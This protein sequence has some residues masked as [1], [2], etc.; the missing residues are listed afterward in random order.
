MS[1]IWGVSMKHPV[2]AVVLLCVSTTFA[3][4]QT[5]TRV[6][7]TELNTFNADIPFL[8][9]QFAVA[10]TNH[11]NAILPVVLESGPRKKMAQQ[12]ASNGCEYLVRIW[13]YT[14]Q[15]V[16]VRPATAVSAL[17]PPVDTRDESATLSYELLAAGGSRVISKG[18]TTKPF[19]HAG[20]AT[21]IFPYRQFAAQ[22]AA[23]IP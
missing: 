15:Q 8:T 1:A 10:K 17:A 13:R 7:V 20:V 14:P 3:L 23:K 11:G 19:I 4:A 5:P 16:A 22:I 12:I 18:T 21:P 2:L 6:C 9:D